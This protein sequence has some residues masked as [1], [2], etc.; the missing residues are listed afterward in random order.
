[1]KYCSS[2][3]AVLSRIVSLS[4]YSWLYCFNL[5]EKSSKLVIDRKSRQLSLPREIHT[6][7]QSVFTVLLKGHWR[8][9][10]QDRRPWTQT[11]IFHP[12]RRKC[13]FSVRVTEWALSERLRN[14]L[15]D[16]PN[17]TGNGSAQ[18]ALSDPA[19]AGGLDWMVSTGAFQPQPFC[20]SVKIFR[21]SLILIQYWCVAGKTTT[22]AEITTW[23]NPFHRFN[24]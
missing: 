7:H 4:S 3:L 15:G 1:M 9:F 16:I 22:S 5:P 6:L 24:S 13:P 8:S 23:Q 21:D 2:L 18:P 12:N 19:W 11:E 14:L 10:L 17:P 20:N